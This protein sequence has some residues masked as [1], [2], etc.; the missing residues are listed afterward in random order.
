MDTGT[1][2]TNRRQVMRAGVAAIVGIGAVIGLGQQISAA[3]GTQARIGR[4][5]VVTAERGSL[6]PAPGGAW[7][8][9]LEGPGTQIMVFTDPPNTHT[10]LVDLDAAFSQIVAD[11][12]QE[13]ASLTVKT[14]DHRVDT[15]ALDFDTVA[16]E[17][18][19]TFAV[20]QARLLNGFTNHLWQGTFE[21]PMLVVNDEDVNEW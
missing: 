18:D 19:S 14:A 20:F 8:L 1:L 2:T 3:N 4:T 17:P 16:H 15:M 6:L 9:R 21:N 7:E 11:A 12:S 5:F 13:T 10:E